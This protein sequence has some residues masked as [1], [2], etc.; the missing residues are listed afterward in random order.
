MKVQDLLEAEQ[1]KTLLKVIKGTP[2]KLLKDFGLGAA[3]DDA[4]KGEFQKIIDKMSPEQQQ[5]IKQTTKGA[6]IEDW[7]NDFKNTAKLEAQVWKNGGVL[8]TDLENMTGTVIAKMSHPSFGRL[9]LEADMTIKNGKFDS[10][11]EIRT[12]SV[13]KGN[14]KIKRNTYD[15]SKFNAATKDVNPK[16]PN[17]AKTVGQA[18]GDVLAQDQ[19]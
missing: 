2:A 5:M 10:I 11:Q 1:Q 18:A 13:N 17:F 9:E 15:L 14:S 12:T 3:M 6:S 8:F 16:D 19:E 7:W 4:A